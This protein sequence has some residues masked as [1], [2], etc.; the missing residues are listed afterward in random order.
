MGEE[1]DPEQYNQSIPSPAGRACV[2]STSSPT[3]G[4]YSNPD[5]ETAA[6]L[7]AVENDDIVPD[8]IKGKHSAD[9]ETGVLNELERSS[10][11]TD[12]INDVRLFERHDTTTSLGQAGLGSVTEDTEEFFGL[13]GY[14]FNEKGKSCC[15]ISSAP[16]PGRRKFVVPQLP[17][18]SKLLERCT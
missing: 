11:D 9:G 8:C 5:L 17:D 1:G 10:W 4:D 6:L 16:V 3:M 13:E 2:S 14:V 12:V 7:R 15:D 18:F